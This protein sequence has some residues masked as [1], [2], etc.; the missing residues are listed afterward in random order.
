M[1][2]NTMCVQYLRIVRVRL[3]STAGGWL[4]M[5]IAV[6][7]FVVGRSNSIW[8]KITDNEMVQKIL[9]VVAYIACFI[10]AILSAVADLNNS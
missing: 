4:F 5:V 8:E 1:D 3:P 10:F 9:K 6:A 7:F 2:I